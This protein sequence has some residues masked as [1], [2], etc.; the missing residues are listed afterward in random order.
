MS[1]RA[2]FTG[3]GPWYRTLFLTDMW[4]RFSFY[5]MQAIL[6][7]WAAAPAAEGGLGLDEPT[8]AALF[9]VYIGGVFVLAMPGGWLGDRVLGER[10]AVL[11]GGLGIMCGHFAM[12]LPARP[13]AYA[14]LLLIAA[15]TGLLKPNM[16][17]L[18]G[19]F[20][21]AGR[22]VEREAAFSVFYMSIQVSALAAPLLVGFLGESVNWHLGFAAAG[23]G[24]AFG[25]AQ[26]AAGRRHFGEVGD[27]PVRRAAPAELRRVGLVAGTVA[28]AVAALLAVD[29]A[30]GTFVPDHLIVP[31]GLVI[32]LAAPVA[33]TGMLRRPGLTAADRARVR[34]FGWLFL[35]AAVFWMLVGQSGSVLNLFAERSTD[36]DVLGWTVPASWFQS[37]TPLFV[38]LVAPVTA[39]VFLRLGPRFG[40]RGKFVTGMA[41]SGASFVVMAGAALAAGSGKAS[42]LWLLAVLFLHACGELVLGPVGLSAAADAAPPAFRVQMLGLWWL[43]CAM[44]MG[45]GSST[46]RVSEAVSPALYF[47]ALGVLA[48]AVAVLLAVRAGSAARRLAYAAPAPT[49]PAP[50]DRT[51]GPAA[52][53]RTTGPLITD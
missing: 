31:V 13:A 37:A 3:H 12:A 29:V 44:G 36:R 23:V 46:A 2:A 18:L 21:D 20:Y 42:P 45:L 11:W 40:V 25:V 9:G 49:A 51:A 24:M 14:G 30:A 27:R 6:V 8:A 17:A 35:A 15:G 7:L 16:S 34:A 33:Y 47:A 39:V 53:P 5:G 22:S 52:G 38:L 10:R 48:L 50:A 32:I 1:V 43:F 4:E 41:L 28:G 26:Y 19:R